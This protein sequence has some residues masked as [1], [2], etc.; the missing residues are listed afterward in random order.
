MM[1]SLYRRGLAGGKAEIASDTILFRYRDELFEFP[2]TIL[3]EQRK[4][5]YIVGLG[6]KCYTAR[7]SVLRALKKELEKKNG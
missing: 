1:P 6:K 3:L 5:K 4:G 7:V 2:G